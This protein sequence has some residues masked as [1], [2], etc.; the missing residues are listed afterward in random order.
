MS[1]KTRISKLTIGRL[2]NLGNY[3]HVRYELT[4]D[5]AEGDSVKLAL[6]NTMRLLK[7]ANPKPPIPTFDYEHAKSILSDPQAWHKNIADRK[8]RKRL[9]A[10]TVKSAKQIV[11]TYDDWKARRK[12]AMDA[13]D[14]IGCERIWKDHKED[15]RDD[16]WD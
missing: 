13:L 12:A 10:E 6:Q 14:A 1:T 7:A 11:K 4:I 2:F 16:D 5:I 15:W 8:E 9:I 3:E